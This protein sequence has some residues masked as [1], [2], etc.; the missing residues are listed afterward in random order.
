MVTDI[1]YLRMAVV[2]PGNA[3]IRTGGDNLVEFDFAV[4]SAFF[5]ETRL[6]K[7]TATATTVVVRFIRGH[8]DEIFFAYHRF[9]DESQIIG[10]FVALAFTDNLAGILNG[11]LDFTVLVP[12]GID[13]QP[14]FPDPLC[15]VGIDGSNFKFM[16]DI[17]FFQSGPD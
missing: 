14:S 6:Q 13:L 4:G 5:G 1:M 7:T 16:V 17:E 8:L 2:A 15:V 12:V 3:I 9:D 11:E 10:D